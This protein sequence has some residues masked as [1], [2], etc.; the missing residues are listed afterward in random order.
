[1][2]K[3]YL[4]TQGL[5]H[6][7]GTD[8]EEKYSLVA[9]AKTRCFLGT[10]ALRKMYIL[11]FAVRIAFLNSFFKMNWINN[12]PKDISFEVV[13][14]VSGIVD[15]QTK[16]SRSFSISTAQIRI[17]YKYRLS[18]AFTVPF[19]YRPNMLICLLNLLRNSN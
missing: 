18:T 11:Q 13:Y 1:M 10:V 6:D 2:Y 16:C 4:V 5:S 3:A 15:F 9:R 17:C 14:M 7:H 8:W 19:Q 12:S